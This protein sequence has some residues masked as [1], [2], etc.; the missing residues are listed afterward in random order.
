M[1][2]FLILTLSFFCG[3]FVC[4]AQ[5]VSDSVFMNVIRIDNK[6]ITKRGNK[7]LIDVSIPTEIKVPIIF[8]NVSVENEIPKDLLFTLYPQY[9]YIMFIVPDWNYYK[10]FSEDTKPTR[11]LTIYKLDRTIHGENI[12][13]IDRV[14]SVNT[15]G[16]VPKIQ[17]VV[18]MQLRS[19]EIEVYH[20][21]T[22]WSTC[23]PIDLAW[24]LTFSPESKNFWKRYAN[25]IGDA[26]R[27]TWGDEG[28]HDA[29]YTLSGLTVR[30]KIQFIEE[31]K[32]LLAKARSK[33]DIAS[34]PQ[35]Y[36]PFR[37]DV[38]R[39]HSNTFFKR[40]ENDLW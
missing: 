37:I 30:E 11:V 31:R 5:N 13:R 21:E 7:T 26:Y 36:T 10:N 38:D 40:I 25:K 22:F 15:Q 19:G 16:I 17:F 33:V 34:T 20:M 9:K 2:R 3:I 4:F 35:I 24:S 29:F 28:E 23:C 32:Q 12:Y 14:D 27:E 1:R 39:R 8:F 6:H 18:D